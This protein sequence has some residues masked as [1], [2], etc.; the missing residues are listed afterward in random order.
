MSLEISKKEREELID[1]LLV[2][3]NDEIEQ[4]GLRIRN[5]TF[6]FDVNSES[7]VHFTNLYNITYEDLVQIINTC[8]SRELLSS[9]N[10]SGRY[11]SMCLTEEGQGRAISVGSAEFAKPLIG[12]TIQ[13]GTLNANAATQI[14]DNNTQ[15]IEYVFNALIDQID[16]ADAPDD[17]KTAA[18]NLLGRF[19]A[20]PLT[21]SI[22][23]A[24]SSV[25]TAK[26]GGA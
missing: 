24:A 11:G 20:H 18:K 26:L 23:G 19:I 15:N 22:I 1:K 17:E 10:I 13:I 14:G 8:M 7:A 5:V 25:I 9:S 21:N 12:S 16:N 4:R 2:S 3:L 6:N